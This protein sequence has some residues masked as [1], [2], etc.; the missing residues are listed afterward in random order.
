MTQFVFGTLPKVVL[1]TAIS[2]LFL[3]GESMSCFVSKARDE[4]PEAHV[5]QCDDAVSSNESLMLWV[6]MFAFVQLTIFPYVTTNYTM[7]NLLRFDFAFREQ[8]Q[9]IFA[10][11]ALGMAI[12]VFASSQDDG[13]SDSGFSSRSVRD[14]LN[15]GRCK[16]NGWPKHAVSEQGAGNELRRAPRTGEKRATT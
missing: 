11:V 4:D 5:E 2:L 6:T 7:A 15:S 8:A 13:Y 14:A 10:G 3:I 16:L 1:N 12:F 9:L